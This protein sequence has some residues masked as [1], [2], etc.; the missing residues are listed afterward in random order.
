MEELKTKIVNQREHEGQL[1]SQIETLKKELK[2]QS[3]YE[4]ELKDQISAL[5]G[6]VSALKGL[7]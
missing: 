7:L 6:Q 5:T 4:D 2:V 3:D 1:R